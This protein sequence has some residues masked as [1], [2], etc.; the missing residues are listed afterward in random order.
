[1]NKENMVVIVCVLALVLLFV[2][3]D[4]VVVGETLCV[5]GHRQIN[6]E[7]FMCEDEVMLWFGLNEYW[8]FI[9]LIPVGL[10]SGWA[11]RDKK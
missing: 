5:D 3:F 11:W 1:M 4:K 2:G 8:A 7:G 9:V 6:L 10:V